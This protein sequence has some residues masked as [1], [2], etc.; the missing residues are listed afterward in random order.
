MFFK[1]LPYLTGGIEETLEGH[2]GRIRF[3]LSRAFETVAEEP[4][5]FL[6]QRFP[7][8]ARLHEPP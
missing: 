3:E 5:F 7:M 1:M 2:E 4:P 8:V 6:R